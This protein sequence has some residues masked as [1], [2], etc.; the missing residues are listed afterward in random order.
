MARARKTF[1]TRI[2]RLN[3]LPRTSK[4]KRSAS[5]LPDLKESHRGR[6]VSHTSSVK[7][8]G[9]R[10]KGEP[11]A[12]SGRRLTIIERRKETLSIKKPTSGHRGRPKGYHV[13]AATRAKESAAHKGKPHPHKGHK[14]SLATREKISAALKG[15]KKSA[16][17]R[18]KMSAAK[19]GHHVSTTTK[20]KISESLKNKLGRKRKTLL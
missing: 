14:Q 8:E 17:T 9:H 16:S 6:L 12:A 3:K 19:L 18:A 13:S 11:V 7:G 5:R 1:R 10:K 15:R 4:P 20:L 2:P